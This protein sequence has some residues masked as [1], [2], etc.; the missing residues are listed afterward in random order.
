[1]LQSDRQSLRRTQ[2]EETPSSAGG[3]RGRTHRHSAGGSRGGSPGGSL[4]NGELSEEHSP[5][6]SGHPRSAKNSHS[7]PGSAGKVELTANG[8]ENGRSGLAHHTPPPSSP[9]VRSPAPSSSSPSPG[10]DSTVLPPP[11]EAPPA[12]TNPTTATEPV[13]ES[14]PN[15]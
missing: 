7:S 2:S 1:M 3:P 12:G 10:P 4:T 13:P 14:L 15:G 8:L 6:A 5:A 9:S 11:T